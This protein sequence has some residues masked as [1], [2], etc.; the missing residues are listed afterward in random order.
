MKKM[1][2]VIVALII[3][4]C[5]GAYA[6][7]MIKRSWNYSMFYKAAVQETICDMVKPE[8][9]KVPCK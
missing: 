9:L 2:A 7:Y 3:V 4:M 6:S 5:G 8:A 1:T